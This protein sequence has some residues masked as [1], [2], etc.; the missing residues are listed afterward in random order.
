MVV[1]VGKLIAART[2]TCAGTWH[3]SNFLSD[4]EKERAVV[5]EKRRNE[6][7]MKIVN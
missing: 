6:R 1:I 4:S 3:E 7:A 2:Y 5:I